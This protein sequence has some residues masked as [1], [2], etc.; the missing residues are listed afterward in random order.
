MVYLH[1]LI[2]TCEF[3]E[4][5]KLHLAILPLVN[6]YSSENLNYTQI[7]NFDEVINCLLRLIYKIFRIIFTDS[8]CYMLFLWG[9]KSVTASD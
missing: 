5:D 2:R 6:I 1:I 7:K 3:A 8:E 9:K 4:T